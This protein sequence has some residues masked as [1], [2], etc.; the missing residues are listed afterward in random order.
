[1]DVLGL[2]SLSS[3]S[4]TNLLVFGAMG[5]AL[6]V[7]I[8]G[9]ALALRANRAAEESRESLDLAE[10]KLKQASSLAE[11]VR[12]L[13]AQVED[14]SARYQE[15]MSQSR[16]AANEPAPIRSEPRSDA[17]AESRE[18]SDRQ[19]ARATGD[20][21]FRRSAFSSDRMDEDHEGPQRSGF[22]W[23]RKR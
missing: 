4:L 19:D 5:A 20:S 15:A 6:M 8:A 14:L 3:G 23:F 12:A 21:D 1:M 9:A 7:F 16:F 17:Y 10:T 13:R 18:L 2:V 11:D 22:G